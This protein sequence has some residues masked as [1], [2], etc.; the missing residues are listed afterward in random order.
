MK[1][2]NL[3]T[4]LLKGSII[5]LM[6]TAVLMTSLLF[7]SC[8]ETTEEDI[9]V[10]DADLIT[11]IETS[12]NQ[13]EVSIEALP[14]RAQ[15]ELTENFPD[16]E[17]YSV[18][19]VENLGFRVNMVTTDGSWTSELNRVFFDRAGRTIEDRRRP[20]FGRRRSCFHLVFPFSVTMPDNTVITLEDRSDRSLIRRW[21]ASNPDT[22]E[23]PTLVFPL[24]I[25]YQDGTIETINNQEDLEAAREGCVRVRCFDLVYP[26][27]LTMP[28]GST[29]TLSSKDDRTLIKEWYRANPG[30]HE[31]PELVYPIDVIYQDGT[32]ETI[33]DATELQA[34]KDNC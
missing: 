27:T 14:A 32:L 4:K 8:S 10:D 9:F 2:T 30:N 25:I 33:N 7:T 20:R 11:A 12:V 15:T 29:I 19:S 18:Q 16:D 24:D 23:R 21:Y 3:E 28:D 5:F 26:Y 17:V 22:N 6:I 13:V 1:A 34:A 31:R